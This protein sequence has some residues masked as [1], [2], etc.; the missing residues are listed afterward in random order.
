MKTTSFFSV[1]LLCAASLGTTSCVNRHALPT[2]AV[3]HPRPVPVEATT[4]CLM[5]GCFE[6]WDEVLQ[7]TDLYREV[8]RQLKLR[9]Y[10]PLDYGPGLIPDLLVYCSVYEG[11]LRFSPVG[12]PGV[13]PPPPRQTL[14]PGS[15][16]I[17]IFDNRLRRITWNGYADG[18]RDGEW[19]ADERLLPRAAQEILH[20]YLG[21]GPLIAGRSTS[22][23]VGGEA[24]TPLPR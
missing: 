8:E 18:L 1:L 13:N 14:R 19:P 6:P 10:R 11:P 21:V 7:P 22:E 20:G 3:P 17:Q 15:V 9:G 12:V 4:F 5:D 2:G 24:E 23:A 16:V